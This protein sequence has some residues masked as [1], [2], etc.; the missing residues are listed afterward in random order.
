MGTDAVPLREAKWDV[1]LVGRRLALLHLAYAKTLV[2][3]FGEERGKEL[4]TKAIK[5]Y[6][7]NIGKKVREQVINQGF[8][9]IPENY[10]VGQSRD[11]PNYGLHE[12]VEEVEAEGKTQLRAY[13]CVLAKVW[14]EYG[15]N[16]LGRLYCSV[17]PAK[18]MAYNP[19]FKLA[20]SKAI[21][22]GDDYCEFCV[23][24]TT[25]KERKDFA[26]AT[27]DWLYIDHC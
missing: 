17:D 16:E 10:G 1:E 9:P 12:R 13:G 24:R 20:H 2:K 8:E 14:K 21:P 3:E 22:D 18:Y 23:H 15:E 26:S 5:N 6:G 27:A 19:D 7:T 11:L 25:A 4:I